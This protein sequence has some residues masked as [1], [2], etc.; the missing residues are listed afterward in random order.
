MNGAPYDI[1]GVREWFGPVLV[2]ADEP[3]F[4]HPW[5]ARVCSSLLMTIAALGVT[6]EGFRWAEERL[7]R[8]Q[9]LA[10]YYQRW[11]GALELLVVEHGVLAPGE[12]D[13]HLAG[14]KPTARGEARR[15]GP[16]RRALT[17]QLVRKIFGPRP[18]WMTRLYPRI[19][20]IHL[21][22]VAPP[23]FALGDPVVVSEAP[24]A[25]HTRRPHYTWGKRGT[26]VSYLFATVPPD[27]SARGEHGKHEHFYTIEFD[28]RELWGDDAEPGTAVR[29]DL[30]ESYLE[31][32]S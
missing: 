2:E 4:H 21:P 32:T 1:G 8:E 22:E 25:G 28:G 23:R 20:D 31:A 10:G 16:A 29:I 18:D 12:L 30:F 15:P 14:V 3:V 27:R 6:E 26:V 17:G 19:E 7:P 24:M 11:L 5:E 9:Y 13:A